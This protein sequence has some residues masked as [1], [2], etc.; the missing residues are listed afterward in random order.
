LL[1]GEFLVQTS[2][3]YSF[4]LNESQFATTLE[5]LHQEAVSP[6]WLIY[7][8]PSM[9]PP[10]PATEPGYLEHPNEAFSYY[11]KKGQTHVVVQEKCA[12]RRAVVVLCR[13]AAAAQKRFGAQDGRIGVVYS[14]RGRPIFTDPAEEHE[15]LSQLQAGAAAA[16][17]WDTLQTDWICLEG[18]LTGAQFQP[19]HAAEQARIAAGVAAVWP[20]TLSHLNSAMATDPEFFALRARMQAR[21]GLVEGLANLCR[22]EASAT[23]WFFSPYH[24]LAAQSGTFFH[25]PHAW[26]MAQLSAFSQGHPTRVRAVRSEVLDLQDHD[27]RRRL[28]EWWQTLS[29][30]GKPGII[31]KPATL[32]LF[33]NHEYLQPAMKVRGREALRMVYGPF[34]TESELLAHH[35]TRAL[36]DR[37]ELVIRHFVLGKEALT[38]FV[39]GQAHAEV[40][41]AITT[42]L[43]IS[44]MDGNP[45]V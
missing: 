29:A 27:H 32:E 35:R 25:Q 10:Q 15:L 4:T 16:G 14:R 33:V 41:Q 36:K 21:S 3:G 30:A 43:A 17:L 7:L 5:L 26:H 24:L 8:P 20:S 9:S 44:T 22:A 37:R 45:L 42:H 40:L 31:V 13:D 12:G 2:T 23:A 11:E 19:G 38:R 1:N 6:R 18:Q 34:Y 28:V 39:A